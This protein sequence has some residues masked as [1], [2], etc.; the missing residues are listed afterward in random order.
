MTPEA[1][2]ALVAESERAHHMRAFGHRP[3][4]QG[5]PPM[6]TIDAFYEDENGRLPGDTLYISTTRMVALR[7][8]QADVECH[9]GALPAPDST[10][11]AGGEDGEPSL[12][13]T[14]EVRT[15][16]DT[17]VQDEAVSD[18]DA[19]YGRKADGTP[20]KRPGRPRNGEANGHA[21]P[22]QEATPATPAGNDAPALSADDSRTFM[23]RLT[24]DLADELERA[25]ARLQTA[26]AEMAEAKSVCDRLVAAH[27]ALTAV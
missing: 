20:R 22:E 2:F 23:D 9:T 5:Q 1:F 18:P 16:S 8:A 11:A 6:E 10:F 4:M 17:A 25:S 15:M 27:H 12:L 14:E 26:E 21:E 7:G 19:P 3:L 24:S 13:T